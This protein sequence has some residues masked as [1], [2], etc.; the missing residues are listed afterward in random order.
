MKIGYCSFVGRATII[1]T[2]GERGRK[3]SWAFVVITDGNDNF[4]LVGSME[5]KGQGKLYFGWNS[6]N[7]RVAYESINDSYYSLYTLF[8][9]KPLN[10]G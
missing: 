9:K 7:C 4:E 1:K 5:M 3:L 2:K 8:K 6:L 10:G